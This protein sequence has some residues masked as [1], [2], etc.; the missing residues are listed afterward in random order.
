VGHFWFTEINE[1]G[2][3]VVVVITKI[4]EPFILFFPFDLV[5]LEL[6][7]GLLFV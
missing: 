3:D 2:V 7:S 6:H 5:L 1:V 4:L